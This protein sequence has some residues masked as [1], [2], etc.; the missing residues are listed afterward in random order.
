MDATGQRT[1]TM[2][3]RRVFAAKH[4]TRWVLA[5]VAAFDRRHLGGALQWLFAQPALKVRTVRPMRR[6][7]PFTGAAV[8]IAFVVFAWAHV[9]P[10]VKVPSTNW[11]CS[12][13][14]LLTADL[15][16]FWIAALAA[17]FAGV[18]V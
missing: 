10:M 13:P 11:T 14:S 2:I 15:N 6:I 3:S 8:W 17:V 16:A 4:T 9:P 18:A 1:G 12:P 5:N 7:I